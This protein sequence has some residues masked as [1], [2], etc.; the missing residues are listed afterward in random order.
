[1]V[2]GVCAITFWGSSPWMWQGVKRSPTVSPSLQTC[3]TISFVV[4]ELG[5][6]FYSYCVLIR[7]N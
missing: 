5:M 6:I 2:A 1:M 4:V 3:L 7:A